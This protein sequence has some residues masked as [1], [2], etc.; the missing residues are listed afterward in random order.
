M[1][2]S[3]MTRQN[4]ESFPRV[5]ASFG[6][7]FGG[8]EDGGGGEAGVAGVVPSLLLL[9]EEDDWK[10]VVQSVLLPVLMCDGCD[11]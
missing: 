2:A 3:D 1:F 4:E 11:A 6:V 5:T 10:A 8:S 7:V 9:Q